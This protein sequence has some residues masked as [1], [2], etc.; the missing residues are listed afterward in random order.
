M[1]MPGHAVVMRDDGAV[2]IHLHPAGTISTAAQ[3]SFVMRQP[4]DTIPGR[5]AGRLTVDSSRVHDS[6]AIASVNALPPSAVGTSSAD[7][8]TVQFPYAFP[9]PGTYRIWVQVK[10][11]GRVLTG[12]FIATVR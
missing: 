9:E 11:N 4:G 8:G 6:H 5:L 10:R 2:F 7:N 1:G 12:A 3:M